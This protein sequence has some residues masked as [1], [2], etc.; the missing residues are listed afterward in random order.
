MKNASLKSSFIG[1]LIL[2]LLIVLCPAKITHSQTQ[3]AKPTVQSLAWLSGCWERTQG[4]R[5]VEEHW[6]KAAGGALLGLSRTLNDGRMTEFE[7]LRI[8]EKD[9]EIFYTAK[10]SRQPEASF[11]LISLKEREAVFE[12]PTHD[13]PQRIIYRRT[14]D[15]A[16]VARIEGA[17]NGQQRGVDF[18]YTRAKCDAVLTN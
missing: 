9:G 5:Y 10:P 13:F 18:P 14:S 7:F 4:K 3:E 11:K 8:H 1:G 17:M 2:G 16:L 6:T 12:N 15:Q